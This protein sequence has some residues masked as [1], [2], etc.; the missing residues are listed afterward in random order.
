MCPLRDDIQ[1][2]LKLFNVILSKG[3]DSIINV[4][5]GDFEGLALTNFKSEFCSGMTDRPP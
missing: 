3:I 5:M 1:L 2:G 4:A